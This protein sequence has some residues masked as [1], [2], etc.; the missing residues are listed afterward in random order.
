MSV[1]TVDFGAGMAQLRS[2]LIFNTAFCVSPPNES[3][4]IVGFGS[5]K[6]AI[7]YPID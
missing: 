1:V 2:V 3:K 7:I 5:A 6:K 4:G